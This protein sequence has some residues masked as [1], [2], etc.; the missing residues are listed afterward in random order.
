MLFGT[1]E[2]ENPLH[3]KLGGYDNVSVAQQ[4]A[5]PT[6]DFLRYTNL[7]KP[8]AQSGDWIDALVVSTDMLVSHCQKKKYNKRVSLS[9]AIA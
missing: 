3:E 4:L 9:C 8:T 1:E 7:I 6:L 5:V 2:T